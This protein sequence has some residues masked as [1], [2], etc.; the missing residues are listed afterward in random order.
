M[1]HQEANSINHGNSQQ[2]FTVNGRLQFIHVPVKKYTKEK[3][4]KKKHK[5]NKS[6]SKK[7]PQGTPAFQ[8]L[9]CAIIIPDNPNLYSCM[10]S[11]GAYTLG[12][13]FHIHL[14]QTHCISLLF[15]KRDPLNEESLL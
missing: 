8:L 11:H 7:N 13:L 10:H 2:L 4:R 15:K 5:K 6:N 9:S 3:R 1:H 14:L 12:S